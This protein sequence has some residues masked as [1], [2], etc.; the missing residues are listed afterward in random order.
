M[1]GILCVVA[2]ISPAAA[3]NISTMWGNIVC[4]GV[5]RDVGLW[6]GP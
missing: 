4:C 2:G 1:A 6:L 5:L 3:H